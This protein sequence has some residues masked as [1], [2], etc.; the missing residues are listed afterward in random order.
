MVMIGHMARQ[1][2]YVDERI[3]ARGMLCRCLHAAND[4]AVAADTPRLIRY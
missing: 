4:Y 2:R 1:K 3:E